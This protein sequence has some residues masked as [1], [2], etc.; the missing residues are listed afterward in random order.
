MPE[1][2]LLPEPCWWIDRDDDW[3][4][5]HHP[6]REA[7][8]AD[9]ADRVRSDYG[10]PLSVAG[11]V[12]IVPG[13][14]RREARRCRE[15]TCPDCGCVTHSQGRDASCAEECGFEFEIA[16]V[17]PDDPAQASL[18]DACGTEGETD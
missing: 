4:I 3:E 9:H 11:A 16:E 15:W 8:E 6:G 2:V 1:A 14:V 7:A 5:S 17:A 12:A 18:F 13:E 10:W